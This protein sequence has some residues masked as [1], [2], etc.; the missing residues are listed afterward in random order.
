MARVTGTPGNDDLLGTQGGDLIH[1]L[2]G[3][4]RVLEKARV[5]QAGL[6]VAMPRRC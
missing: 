2:A 5:T 1:A 4:D 3:N 6:R